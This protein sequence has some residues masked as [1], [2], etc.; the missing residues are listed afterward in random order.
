[1]RL[2]LVAVVLLSGCAVGVGRLP[3]PTGALLERRVDERKVV[4]GG[5]DYVLVTSSETAADFPLSVVGG[6]TP[7]VALLLP[8]AT[9]SSPGTAGVGPGFAVH[10]DLGFTPTRPRPRGG[11]VT[12]VSLQ[13]QLAREE[14]DY[15]GG[16][17]VGLVHHAVTTY[18][19]AGFGPWGVEGGVG[20]L[21]GGTFGLGGH[22]EL[23]SDAPF[24]HGASPGAGARLAARGTLALFEGN[25][26]GQVALRAEVAWQHLWPTQPSVPVGVPAGLGAVTFGVEVVTS[27]F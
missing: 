3:T 21:I 23:F 27:F 8:T 6:V 11:R 10:V 19:G 9:T 1:M 13:Y 24:V 15:A 26:P 18:V 25:L 20:G 2:G 22:D 7:L 5:K 4:G 14:L 16:Y 17:S 12:T